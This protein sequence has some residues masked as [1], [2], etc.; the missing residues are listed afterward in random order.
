IDARGGIGNNDNKNPNPVV[1]DDAILGFDHGISP[2]GESR[3]G[4]F[5]EYKTTY[6]I[7][8]H[9]IFKEL[10]TPNRFVYRPG[11]GHPANVPLTKDPTFN[12]EA[13]IDG[14]HVVLVEDAEVGRT[15]TR[16]DLG[17]APEEKVESIIYNFT[18]APS[19]MLNR[20]KPKYYFEVESGYVGEVKNTFKVHGTD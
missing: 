9:L 10:R 6:R 2:L 13:S 7:D 8:E 15:Y 20:G 14:Q 18:Y 11:S 19:G 4:D 17:I 3:Q 16:G 5:I 12:L 1:Y